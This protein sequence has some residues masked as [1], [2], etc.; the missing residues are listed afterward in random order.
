[1]NVQCSCS[2]AKFLLGQIVTTRSARHRLTQDD[3]FSELVRHRSGD[4]GDIGQEDRQANELALE[5]G[6]WLVSMYR[7]GNGETFWIITEADRSATTV[8][9]P[10][11]Y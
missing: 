10:E 4:W 9:M 3:I 5:K 8:L 1:M 7:A 2:A 11:D 6:S